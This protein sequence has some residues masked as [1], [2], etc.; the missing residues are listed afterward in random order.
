M[1]MLLIPIKLTTKTPKYMSVEQ[2][3]KSMEEEIETL[4]VNVELLL[5]A[6]SRLRYNGKTLLTMELEEQIKKRN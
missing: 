3:I 6:L 2:K 4:R 1:L 5:G